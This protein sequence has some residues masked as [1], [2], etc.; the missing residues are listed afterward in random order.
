MF[1]FLQDLKL[2]TKLLGAFL[3]VIGLTL[4]VSAVTLISQIRSQATVDHLVK[5]DSLVTVRIVQSRLAV[6]RMRQNEKDSLLHYREA[7]LA[8]GRAD[9]VATV[10]A[11]AASLHEKLAE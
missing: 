8:K 5:V 1:S 9:Y 11:E 2:R 6:S 4:V 10:Q 3:I 7:G